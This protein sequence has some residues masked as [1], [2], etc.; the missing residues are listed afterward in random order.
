M[1]R[2]SSNSHWSCA[3]IE[4]GRSVW[5]FAMNVSTFMRFVSAVLKHCGRAYIQEP[6]LSWCCG[7]HHHHHHHHEHARKFS[8]FYHLR[9]RFIRTESTSNP[10][11]LTSLEYI[12]ALNRSND[13]LARD[14]WHFQ[15]A[16]S[17]RYKTAVWVCHRLTV[18][19]WVEMKGILYAEQEEP[20]SWRLSWWNPL[21]DII[22]LTPSMR[23]HSPTTWMQRHARLVETTRVE[24]LEK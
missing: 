22:H 24:T 1:R 21:Q 14:S 9:I 6:I 12:T 4:R 5:T 13:T 17:A 15:G 23:S 3:R 7:H 10:I 8:R 19:W 11:W 2:F 18:T 16:G 20:V